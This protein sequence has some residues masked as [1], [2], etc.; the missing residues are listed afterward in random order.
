MLSMLVGDN[1]II[2]VCKIMQNSILSE[3]YLKEFFEDFIS[4]AVLN[5]T[6]AMPK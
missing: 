6:R 5:E 2:F 1:R 4:N 3:Q